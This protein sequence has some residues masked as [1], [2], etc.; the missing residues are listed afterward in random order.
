MRG[1]FPGATVSFPIV[2][3]TGSLRCRLVIDANA[4][5]NGCREERRL[6]LVRYRFENRLQL[7][8]EAH[9]EHLVGFVENEE[10]DAAQIKRSRGGSDRARGR[11]S[12]RHVDA[13]LE[14]AQ[15]L[16]DRGTAEHRQD[17]NMQH[18]AVLVHGLGD[19]H[20]QFARRHQHQRADRMI[21]HPQSGRYAVR[22]A[23]RTPPSFRYPSPLGRER[24][25]RQAA[26]E[27]P[28]AES[29]SVL[30]NRARSLR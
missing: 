13:A 18:A 10:F 22:A 12:R 7:V 9:V 1:C 3:C 4:R 19:L 5:G 26:A 15:L 8:G 25:D 30:H 24:R 21:A 23:A 20:R 27:S 16:R 17:V 28:R 2:T 11:A 6:P 29:R 14:R